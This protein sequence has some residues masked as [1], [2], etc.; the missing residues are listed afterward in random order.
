MSS[1]HFIIQLLA[2]FLSAIGCYSAEKSD[3]LRFAKGWP[4]P[5]LSEIEALRIA[6][7]TAIAHKYDVNQ[8]S[9][10]DIFYMP[11]GGYWQVNIYC[12]SNMAGIGVLVGDKSGKAVLYDFEIFKAQQSVPDYRRQSAPQS[13]P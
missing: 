10:T 11:R 13:E 3:S 9:E 2:I 4:P 1:R 6:Q 5:Y 7:E 12:V 8:Y